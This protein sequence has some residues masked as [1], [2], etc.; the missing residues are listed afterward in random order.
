MPGHLDN[1]LTLTVAIVTALVI[2]WGWLSR[3]SAC[4]EAHEP[5][6]LVS[7]PECG[8]AALTTDLHDHCGRCA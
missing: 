3:K 7:C 5:L 4:G 1:N 2:V 8:A 6:R